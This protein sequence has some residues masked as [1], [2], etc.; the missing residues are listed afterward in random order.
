M[1]WKGGGPLAISQQLQ[2]REAGIRDA[3][4]EM[5][6]EVATEA[7]N[8]QRELIEHAETET[9][10]RRA[11]SGRGVP[12]R[13]ETGTMFNGVSGSATWTENGT[14]SARWGWRDPEDYFT[15]QD[16]GTRYIA[17]AHSLLTSFLT[18][19]TTFVRRLRELTRTG[20]A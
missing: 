19:R 10:R 1:Q 17:P 16:E 8:Q 2:V 13:V 20:T 6:I 15:A 7:R 12:G 4:H 18:A 5:M 11:A 3:A 9:G 14:L